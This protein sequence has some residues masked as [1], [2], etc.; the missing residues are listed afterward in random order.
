MLKI[1]SNAYKTARFSLSVAF[2]A[3]NNGRI[4]PEYGPL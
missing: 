2:L 4:R 3:Q 1:A